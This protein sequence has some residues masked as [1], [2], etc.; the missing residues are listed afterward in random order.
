MFA[1][2]DYSP[3]FSSNFGVSTRSFEIFI[4]SEETEEFK[5]CMT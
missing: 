3:V 5:D 1:L 4:I 2:L